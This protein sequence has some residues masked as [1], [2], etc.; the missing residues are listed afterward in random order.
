M[1]VPRD[2]VRVGLNY[3]GHQSP[4]PQSGCI[5]EEGRQDEERAGCKALGY[6]LSAVLIQQCM[7]LSAMRNGS[8]ISAL[9]VDVGAVERNAMKCART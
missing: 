1:T 5:E 4:C 7:C 3:G 6:R 9:C 2:Q 8:L